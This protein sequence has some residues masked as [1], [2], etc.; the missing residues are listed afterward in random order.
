M[1]ENKL[2]RKKR[3]QKTLVH[4][5]R[6]AGFATGGRHTYQESKGWRAKR[7]PTQS[8][9]NYVN[10]GP[11][12]IQSVN[13]HPGLVQIRLFLAVREHFATTSWSR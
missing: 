7:H 8:S 2:A 6:L 13:G 12:Q 5:R 3:A 11:Y 9:R 10:L 4:E 1:L